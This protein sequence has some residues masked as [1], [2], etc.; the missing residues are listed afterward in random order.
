M[1]GN[2]AGLS[3]AIFTGGLPP[4]RTHVD[5]VYVR[6][7]ANVVARSRAYYARYPG[8]RERVRQLRGLIDDGPV[9][10][11]DGDPLT[12]A[13]M[14]QHGI[15]LGQSNGFE[16]LHHLLELPFDSPAFLH[17]AQAGLGRS[18]QR[19]AEGGG[20]GDHRR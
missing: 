5:E 12:W 20:E 9:R 13:R 17:D 8:D 18:A 14:R 3:G 4:L 1:P 10:L 6:T 11:P 7:Y 19:R 16:R 2:P 15:W